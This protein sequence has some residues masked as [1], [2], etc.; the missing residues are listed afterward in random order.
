MS[1]D[2][3]SP[4]PAGATLRYTVMQSAYWGA[5]CVIMTFS[6]VYLL[7]RGFS[8]AKIGVLISVSS[9]I[10]AALQPVM[11]RWVDRMVRVSLREF[12]ACLV[13]VQLAA[14]GLLL[15]APGKAVQA[16]LYGLLI[17]LL[18]IIMPLCSALGMDCVNR[19]IPLN[20]GLA[21]GAGSV[22]YGVFSSL[23]G[24]LVLRFGEVSLPLALLLLHGCLLLSVVTFRLSGPGE[25]EP[26][27]PAA[28]AEPGKRGK[29]FLLQYRG[30]TLLLV[31][32]ICLFI[33]HTTLNTFA[34]QIVK[35]LGGTS[36]EMGYMLFIQSIWELPVM[37]CFAAMLKRA[38]SRVWVR[39]SGIS[40]FLH[41]LGA[42]VAPTMGVLYAAQIFEMPGYALYTIASVYY[43]NESVGEGDRVQGQAYFTMA[44]TLGSV[45]ASFVGG[46]LLDL[47]GAAA[48]LA[49]ATLTGAVGMG[50]LLVQLRQG[51][52]VFRPRQG[53]ETVHAAQ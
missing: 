50:I 32:V 41:A 5:Y 29:P 11:S 18:M 30:V 17:S 28:A 7:A 25:A 16:L 20:F 6:S 52:P 8:N 13:L 10:S 33:S 31:G 49:F 37:F 38:G 47:A 2:R 44:I 43:I 14:S 26:A 21:R 15:L 39:I 34:F 27:A 22:A 53:K 40:F 9:V 35:P 48:L 1:Q 12:C 42:W 23:C 46:F 3:R 19:Q 51:G 24:V 36:E 45:L 4:R